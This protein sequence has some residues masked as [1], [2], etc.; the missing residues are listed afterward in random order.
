[1][2]ASYSNTY[3]V[4]I[5]LGLDED[6]GNGAIDLVKGLLGARNSTESVKSVWTDQFQA[7]A[8]RFG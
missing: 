8:L 3:K 4:A 5:W 6:N 7:T 2:T 1:M